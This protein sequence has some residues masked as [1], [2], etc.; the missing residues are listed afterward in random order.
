MLP[1]LDVS[2]LESQ[3][4][5]PPRMAA[6]FCIV[7]SFSG[8]SPYYRAHLLQRK[9]RK[10]K[11]WLAV[12]NPSNLHF[13][14]GVLLQSLSHLGFFFFV[15][16]SAA[17]DKVWIPLLVREVRAQTLSELCGSDSWQRQM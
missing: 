15:T 3:V 11:P 9:R 5:S 12:Q 1:P 16:R 17:R 2:T 7:P 14:H 4:R 10:D 6:V 8:V 13:A